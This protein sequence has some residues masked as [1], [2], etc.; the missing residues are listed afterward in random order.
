MAGSEIGREWVGSAVRKA[1]RHAVVR[2]FLDHSVLLLVS[3]SLSRL[4]IAQTDQDSLSDE[5]TGDLAVEWRGS[6]ATPFSSS[7]GSFTAF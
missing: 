2:D 7:P 6:E 1:N 3:I 5:L 4:D